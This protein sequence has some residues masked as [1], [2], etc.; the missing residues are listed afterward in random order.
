[1]E[2]KPMVYNHGPSYK[3]LRETFNSEKVTNFSVELF[4]LSGAFERALSKQCIFT[5]PVKLPP[6]ATPYGIHRKNG[7]ATP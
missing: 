4:S 5:L 6:P 1:M 2:Q 3:L 7:A